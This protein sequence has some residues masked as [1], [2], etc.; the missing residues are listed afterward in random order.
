MTALDKQ[1]AA[2]PTGAFLF[3]APDSPQAGATVRLFVDTNPL[4]VNSNEELQKALTEPGVLQGEPVKVAGSMCADLTGTNVRM[5]RV[6]PRPVSGN[7]RPCGSTGDDPAQVSPPPASNEPRSTGSMG[8]NPI[9]VLP[10]GEQS[11][12]SSRPAQWIWQIEATGEGPPELILD[13]QARLPGGQWIPVQPPITHTWDK[14][15][16][17]PEKPKPGDV[18]VS[19]PA[20]SASWTNV[21][22]FALIL[23]LV[24]ATASGVTF[25]V[26]RAR[27]AR[28]PPA[29]PAAT[30]APPPVP[31][32]GPALKTRVVVIH[33]R[34]ERVQAER[35]CEALNATRCEFIYALPGFAEDS[36]EWR[37]HFLDAYANA[38]AVLVLLTGAALLESGFGWQVEQVMSKQGLQQL[39][40]YPVVLDQ[41]VTRAAST[42]ARL[43]DRAWFQGAAPEDVSEV[44]EI[45]NSLE[46]SILRSI[47]CFL[48][49]SRK[50][51]VE[52]ADRLWTDLDNRGIRCWRD[53]SDIPGGA[54]WERQIATAIEKSTHVLFLISPKSL[55][56][57]HVGD[58]VTY[59][60]DRNKVVIPLLSA[61]LLL[62]F[63]FHR[64]QAIPLYLGY[65]A[66]FERLVRDL[67]TPK[68]KAQTGTG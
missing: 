45:L 16:P 39:P 47:E 13:L 30:P 67:T 61:D 5:R 2:L 7:E 32:P 8:V 68:A 18:M 41:Q 46:P 6:F 59:A 17:P 14:P 57:P 56:S 28:P 55:E 24:A 50:D 12:S 4:F 29:Q 20:P 63:G 19:V 64:I 60:R 10:R 53:T 15:P 36:L 43:S 23:F 26:M 25:A 58:E 54:E 38:D 3:A 49:Y 51:G 9:F 37:R 11:L 44:G 35:F 27:A 33:G 1:L 40:V 66:G 65:E 34:D 31:P 21:S 48:S 52:L 62:P 42:L 22:L